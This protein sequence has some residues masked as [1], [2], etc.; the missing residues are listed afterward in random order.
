[1]RRGSRHLEEVQEQMY[2]FYPCRI[3]MEWMEE[4]EDVGGP[5]GESVNIVNPKK[6]TYDL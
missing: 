5:C 2:I 1:M 3:V 4:G 6:C